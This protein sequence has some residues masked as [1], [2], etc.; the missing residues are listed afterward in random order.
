MYGINICCHQYT[1][2]SSTFIRLVLLSV[3]VMNLLHNK[4]NNIFRH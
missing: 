4:V 1:V 2:M 3:A